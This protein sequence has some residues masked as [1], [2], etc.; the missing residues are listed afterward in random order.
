MVTLDQANEV[1]EQMELDMKF[2]PSKPRIQAKIAIELMDMVNWPPGRRMP[3]D[4]FG[5][6][7]RYVEPIYRLER[8]ARSLRAVKEWPGMAEIRAAYCLMYEPADGKEG[9]VC[10]I[11]GFTPEDCE[12]QLA[13]REP[14][15]Y[16]QQVGDVPIAGLLEGVKN[17]AADLR[18][19]DKSS[20]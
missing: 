5:H 12:A 20:S 2:F 3:V 10:S 1:V 8:L 11:P 9:G 13:S 15:K 6:S 19:A 18:I 14:V 7:V 17:G 16:L 4:R